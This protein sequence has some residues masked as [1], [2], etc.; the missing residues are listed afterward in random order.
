VGVTATPRGLGARVLP[1]L[2]ALLIDPSWRSVHVRRG[3]GREDGEIFAIALPDDRAGRA[4]ELEGLK[5]FRFDVVTVDLEGGWS[6][7]GWSDALDLAP[8]GFV[9]MEPEGRTVAWDVGLRWEIRMEEGD[10][11]G[12]LGWSLGPLRT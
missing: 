3:P 1:H 7:G 4:R 12:G 9:L 11:E 2:P 5:A 8:V 6:D 10:G